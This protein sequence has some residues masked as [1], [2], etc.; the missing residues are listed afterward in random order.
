MKERREADTPRRSPRPLRCFTTGER[1]ENAARQERGGNR[2]KP[3]YGSSGQEP[4]APGGSGREDLSARYFGLADSGR[5]LRRS[6]YCSSSLPSRE[7]D[8]CQ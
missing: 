1:P 3:L 6:T 5:S 4:R 8:Q 7:E 2:L